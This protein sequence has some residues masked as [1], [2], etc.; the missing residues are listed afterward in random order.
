MTRIST[1]AHQTHVKIK[2]NVWMELEATTASA[3]R[4]LTVHTA[5]MI[6]TSALAQIARTKPA[7]LTLSMGFTAL[8]RKDSLEKRA[9]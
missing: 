5:N 8:V 9:K 1:N 2:L 7:V 6:L 4:D 3:L